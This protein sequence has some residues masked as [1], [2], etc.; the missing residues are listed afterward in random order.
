[1]NEIIAARL[2]YN[3]WKTISEVFYEPLYIT[4]VNPRIVIRQHNGTKELRVD[5]YECDEDLII[6]PTN[7]GTNDPRAKWFRDAI[8]GRS[9]NPLRVRFLGAHLELRS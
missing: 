3:D 8:V 2:D 7:A 6:T 4:S 5:V 1:M 9:Y